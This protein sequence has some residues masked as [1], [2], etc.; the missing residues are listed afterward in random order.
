[1]TLNHSS[2]IPYMRQYQIPVDAAPCP[3]HRH[4]GCRPPP[5]SAHPNLFVE[6]LSER[7]IAALRSGLLKIGSMWLYVTP[8]R[9]SSYLWRRSPGLRCLSLSG[10]HWLSVEAKQ[11]P[12]R[13]VQGFRIT[14]SQFT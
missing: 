10:W 6:R 12:A 9:K 2:G 1:M 4:Y 14:G 13:I 7:L 11:L 5:P 8:A 3:R